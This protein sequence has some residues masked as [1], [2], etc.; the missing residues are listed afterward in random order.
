MKK[1]VFLF[2]VLLFFPLFF[3]PLALA[4][5]DGQDGQITVRARVE[6]V[7]A[8]EMVSTP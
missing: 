1:T 4:V 5:S 6:E 2:C 3:S 7:L 8:D